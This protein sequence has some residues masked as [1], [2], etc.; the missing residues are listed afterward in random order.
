MA[1]LEFDV[2]ALRTLE[3]LEDDP[4]RAALAAAVN[5]V[6]DLLETDPGAR[7]L[8]RA[9]F[10]YPPL[11]YVTVAADRETWV[12]LWEPHPTDPDINVVHYLGP[13]SFT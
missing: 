7:R 5:E 13:A 8:R 1:D 4:T 9:R 11:W 3:A 10:Q 6:L 12:L 2:E